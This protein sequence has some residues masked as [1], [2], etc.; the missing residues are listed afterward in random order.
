MNGG[1]SLVISL[2]RFHHKYKKKQMG[3]GKLENNNSTAPQKK[4]QFQ[5]E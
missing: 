3:T 5:F 2:R 1:P 4:V